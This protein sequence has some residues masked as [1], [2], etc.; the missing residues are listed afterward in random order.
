VKTGQGIEANEI[1]LGVLVD[2]TGPFASQGKDVSQ[3]EQLYWEKVNEDGGVCGQYEVTLDVQD[4][5]NVVQTAVQLYTG[6]K[7][8]V[9]A[10]QSTLG[11]PI[12]AALGEQ[13]EADNMLN[14]PEAWARELTEVPVNMVV[15]TTY[16]L[17]MINGID[18]LLQEGLLQEG[19]TVGHIYFLGEYG[20]GAL[21]G[22]RY[23]AE[24]HDLTLIEQQIQPTDADMTA[25]VTAFAADGVDAILLSGGPNQTASVASVA[26]A[27]GLDVPMVGN[28]PSYAAGLYGTPAGPTL[29]E[30]FYLAS[31]IPDGTDTGSFLEEYQERFD[32]DSVTLGA[33]HGYADAM[34]MDQVLEEACASA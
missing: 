22:S 3:A 21:E 18:H 25:Q 31:S 34:V 8:S 11:S 27:Q 7:S 28:G 33:V 1:S 20:Q 12:N 32:T 5:T 26:A 29:E 10:M 30:H 19:D 14:I 15:G 24:Q 16:D 9:L 13:F 17:E 4:H 2:L 6:M 23:M